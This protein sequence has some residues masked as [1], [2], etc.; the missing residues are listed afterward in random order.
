MSTL[1]GFLAQFQSSVALAAQDIQN[2]AERTIRRLD[3]QTELPRTP[4]PETF[5]LALPAELLWAVIIAALAVLLY[6]SRDF[7]IPILGFRRHRSREEEENDATQARPRATEIMLGRA[8]ELAARGNYV[9]AMHILLLQSIIDMR[10]RLND[11][12]AASMT[13]REILARAPLPPEGRLSLRD[14]VSRVE[15]SYFGQRPATRSDY[16][17]CRAS[18]NTLAQVLRGVR[19]QDAPR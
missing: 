12:F 8:D 15:R 1:F 19:W 13:S 18:F 17:A 5:R 2:L 6:A 11:Q 7:I 3:L 9:E 10:E 4:A 14:I 16:E